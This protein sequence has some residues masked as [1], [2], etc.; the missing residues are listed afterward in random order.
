[1]E[2]AMAAT[3]QLS[4]SELLASLK[5]I[6]ADTHL[7]EPHDLWLKRAPRALK[8]RV[9]QVKRW[10]DGVA[11]VI[12]GDKSIGDKA[13]SSCSVT[14][15]GSKADGIAQM[16]MTIEEA[17]PAAYDVGA[18]LE[19]MDQMGVWAQVVYPNLLGFGG[20]K[21]VIVDPE[22]RLACVQIYNDAMAELQADSGQR[23][24]PMAL[25]PWWDVKQAVA[26]SERCARMGLRGI[27]I[28]SDPHQS[29]DR[30]GRR[31]PDLG[32]DY[33][34]PLWEA[35]GSLKM[36][37]NFHIGGSES[38]MDWVGQAPWPSLGSLAAEP[39]GGG[40]DP[41]AASV[42]AVMMFLDNARVLSNLIM[43][44][45]LDRYP[46]VQFVSVE[47]GV[48]WIPFVL[49]GLD[50]QYSEFTRQGRL[51]RK[52]SEYFRSNFHACFWFEKRDIASTIRAVGLNNV[53]FE[54][55]FPHPTCLYPASLSEVVDA[56]SDLS[57]VERGKVMSGNAAA[58][59][60]IPLN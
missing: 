41:H 42:G 13:L 36:P 17:H 9:P 47:S 37:V 14:R 30:D 56:L 1:M 43:T 32:A 29:V 22:L 40:V 55:D 59:Y 33:W 15:D 31:L 21:S 39:A 51:Q 44:G 46:D 25:L 28:N 3:A 11:W 26:E 4:S 8:D 58:L 54:T 2:D 35:C 18:R 7:T 38:S 34:A 45:M 52:P 12:D 19:A 5:V 57:D 50:Y 23:L 20:Q 53:M 27:N 48:G 16:K 60:K 6:D 49:E 24:F 10:G